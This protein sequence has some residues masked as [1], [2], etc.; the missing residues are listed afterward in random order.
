MTHIWCNGQWLDPSGF[1]IAPTDRSLM[2][3]LGLFETILALD[4]NPV[5][6][7]LHLAR[8]A[9]G[10][11][12]LGWS[13]VIHDP[14][15]IMS[16]L[17]VRNGFT[18]GRGR[19]RLSITGGSGVIGDLTAGNDRLVMMTASRAPEP[20]A[21]TT[22][23]LS[24]FLRNERAALAG[25]KCSSYAEN[26]VA[27]DHARRLGFEETVFINTAGNLCE[28]ATSNLFLVKE[29]KLLTPS[30]ASG[31]LPGVIR[32]LVI[33]LAGRLGLSCVET[34]LPAA[35]IHE[36]DEIFLTSSIRGVMGISRFEQRGLP[37]GPLT[38][39]LRLAWNDE[40]HRECGG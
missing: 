12:R 31:C 34:D 28:A 17:L 16:G 8:L 22:A 39:K 35:L 6:A 24:P 20:P 13:F 3:G 30:L 40:V 10:C 27:L 37:V 14:R 19:I 29:G 5:F 36:A 38:G 25:L 26:L 1:H 21:T 32:E 15:E 7:E 18:T 4:G 9:A 11:A 2:H 33:G 23:N